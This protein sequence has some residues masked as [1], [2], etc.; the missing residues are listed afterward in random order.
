MK[1]IA[2]YV[3]FTFLLA[4]FSVSISFA[5]TPNISPVSV[6]TSSPIIGDAFT[7][8]ASMS[9]A[10]SGNNYYL[11]CRIGPNSSSLSDG[12]TYNSQTS[13]WLDDT[14]S[15]GA[16]TDMPQITIGSD[17][18]WQGS[19]QCRIKTTAS[20]ETKVIFVRACLNSNNSCGIS[21]QSA[22]SLSLNPIFPTS[23]P[24]PSP[25]PTNI[26]T[27]TNTPTP[28]K[29][30]TSTPTPAPTLTPTKS[31]IPTITTTP[32]EEISRT[33]NVLGVSEN[34]KKSDSTNNAQVKSIHSENLTGKIFLLLGIISL[35]LCGIVIFWQNKKAI[36]E[37]FRT[38][39]WQN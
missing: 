28:T 3:A 4:V 32:T 35:L 2:I 19:I 7:L 21:F 1:A 33:Q 30:P 11:K 27:P 14:G 38:D 13:Q 23:T 6:S 25:T 10:T 22:N 36:F 24:T 34:D 37:R 29:T 18:S 16:W 17:G 9:A 39:E 8:N 12:Q 5:A 26:P 31:I 20:D 15:T